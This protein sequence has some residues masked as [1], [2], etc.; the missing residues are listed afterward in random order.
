[1]NS[2]HTNLTLTQEQADL[3]LAAWQGSPLP[4]TGIR[5]LQGGMIN[6][7]L[8]LDFATA[9]FSAVIKLTSP[10]NSFAAEA[11]ALEYLRTHT[12]FP[13]PQVYL[14]DDTA[15]VIPYAFLLIETIPGEC[16]EG[17]Q[18]SG[19]EYDQVDRQLA[20]TLLALHSHTRERYGEI[21]EPSGPAQWTD[22]FLPRL[23]ESRAYPQVSER[24]APAVLAD[25]DRAIGQAEGALRDQGVPTLIH[26]DIWAGNLILAPAPKPQGGWRL[27][28]IVDPGI[29]YADVEYELAYLEVFN[30]RRQAFFETY[31]VHTPLRPGYAYRR[32][33]YWLNTALIHVGLFGDA[34]YCEFTAQ[35]AA[36]ICTSPAHQVK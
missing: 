15:Q 29:H 26:G 21:D 11:R 1:M 36:G 17:I 16:M 14:L 23:L 6:T 32:L 18:L 35:I 30:T 27:S 34:H 31:L 7:V 5:R 28:G 9:P 20:E 33:F 10:G 2:M 13:S 4:C 8:A 25:V 12:R 19:A 3:V 24:L 22:V